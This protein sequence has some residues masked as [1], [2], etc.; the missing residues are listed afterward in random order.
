[1]QKFTPRVMT[2]LNEKFYRVSSLA[3]ELMAI[4]DP[5]GF[6]IFMP[7]EESDEVLGDAIRRALAASR[8]VSRDYINQIINSGEQ[9]RRGDEENL[10]MMKKFGYAGKRALYKSMKFCP[11][12]VIS[13]GIEFQPT[14]R[15]GL[16][17]FTV[18]TNLDLVP[19]IV[20]QTASDMELGLALREAF[21]RCT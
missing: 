8:P 1:M 12:S 18:R 4:S 15:K 6:K 7:P 21:T 2:L 20:P 13:E 9:K 3:V 11:V 19:V 16:D 5:E 10:L 14:H 17:G